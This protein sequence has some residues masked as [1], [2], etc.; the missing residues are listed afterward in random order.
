MVTDYLNYTLSLPERT[1]RSTAA[2]LS[3]IAR[4]SA[5]FLV[6]TAFQDSKTYR[7]FVK[8]MLDMVAHDVGGV[9]RAE[10]ETP[11][12]AMQVEGYVAKK[13]R[14]LVYGSR[15]HGDASRFAADDSGDP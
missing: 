7:T 15:W 6:P 13:N 10:G 3:G 12:P 4:E 8:Q 11:D 2:L 9:K 5:E 1:V 14:G